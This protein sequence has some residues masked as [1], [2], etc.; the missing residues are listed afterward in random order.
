ME[1]VDRGGTYISTGGVYISYNT[2][3]L[4]HCRYKGTNN[5]Y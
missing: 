5:A 4:I 3:I 1:N 2:M